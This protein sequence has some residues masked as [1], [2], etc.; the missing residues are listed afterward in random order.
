M[1]VLKTFVSESFYENFNIIFM[2]NIKDCQKKK[3]FLFFNNFFFLKPMK[4]GYVLTF[5][6]DKL[7]QWITNEN[8]DSGVF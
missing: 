4:L 7:N 8:C 2:R 1:S 6:L 5:S 3:I